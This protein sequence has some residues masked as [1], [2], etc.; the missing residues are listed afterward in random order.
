MN[1]RHPDALKEVLVTMTR[2]A[3][4]TAL[5]AA[6]G[7]SSYAQSLRERVQQGVSKVQQG[8]AGVAERLEGATVHF[9]S[10]EEGTPVFLITVFA[11][12]EKPHL[13]RAETEAVTARAVAS[14]SRCPTSPHRPCPKGNRPRGARRA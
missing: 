13:I 9:F 11:K 2:L 7:T 8:A 12:S 1:H 6:L 3:V 5:V 14:T 4:L 10:P